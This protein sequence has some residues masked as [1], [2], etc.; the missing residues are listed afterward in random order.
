MLERELERQ[1][2]QISLVASENYSW[3]P[4]LRA[5][6]NIAANKLADGYP[7]ARNSGCENLDAIEDLAIERAKLLFGAEHANVQPLSGA[8]ANLAVFWRAWIATT[9]SLRSRPRDGGHL[10]RGLPTNISG[11]FYRCVHYGVDVETGRVRLE[12]VQ[13]LAH[14]HRPKLIICGGSA[15]PR[16]VEVG[17]FGRSPTRPVR[18]CS[19]TWLISLA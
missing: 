19:A 8:A 10:T 6:G 18:S 9:L 16:V 2:G 1:R 14:E 5:L 12:E 15:Y 7:G 13:R 11:R 17:L 4:V 3:R